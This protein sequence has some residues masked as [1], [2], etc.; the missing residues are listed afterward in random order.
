[1][2]PS[3][4]V[5]LRGSNTARMRPPPA[6]ARLNRRLSPSSVVR[7]AVGWWA[8][9]SYTVMEWPSRATV[10]RTSMRR[11][12][13]SKLA[14]ASAACAGVTP[15][16]SAAAMAASALSWLWVPVSVHSTRATTWPRCSTSKACG[17]PCAVKSLTAAPKLRSSL[18]S[19]MCRTRSS[20]SSS[21][22]ATTRPEPGTVRTRW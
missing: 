4:M 17:S 20:D 14:R 21:P 2:V 19:P 1:M 18:H 8:K 11:R 16:C 13:F 3:F 5:L 12:T 15:T 6:C 10:P 22:L 7:M 9:S